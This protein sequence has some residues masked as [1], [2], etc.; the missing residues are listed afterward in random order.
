MGNAC[1]RRFYDSINRDESY[2][3]A[4]DFINLQGSD[5]KAKSTLPT[6]LTLRGWIGNVG[7]PGIKPRSTSFDNTYFKLIIGDRGFIYSI[8]WDMDEPS[9]LES[10]KALT[11]KVHTKV[12]K[13]GGCL[14]VG[15]ILKSVDTDDDVPTYMRVGSYSC[16]ECP[17]YDPLIDPGFELKN[18]EERKQALMSAPLIRLV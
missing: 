16:H 1:H 6:E 17:G 3:D 10:T 13:N 2:T 4:V 12:G 7:Y 5:D 15:L 9:S 14:Y 11:I 18:R 8:N